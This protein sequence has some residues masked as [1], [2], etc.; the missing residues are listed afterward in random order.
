VGLGPSLAVLGG[1]AAPQQAEAA[2]TTVVNCDDPRQQEQPVVPLLQSYL[3]QVPKRIVDTREALGGHSGPV[4][5]GCTLRLDLSNSIVPDAATSVAL[6]LTA[7]SG[8]RGFMTVFPCSSGRPTP[9]NVNIRTDAPTPNLVVAVPDD[10]RTVCIYSHVDSDMVIDV[11][12]WWGDG[13]DRFTPIDPVR[14]YD[15]RELLPPVKLPAGGIRNLQIGGVYVPDDATSVVINLTAT[16]SDAP[17]WMVAYPCGKAPPKASNLN[18]AKGDI[19]AVAA[20]VKLG[21]SNFG[22]GQICFQTLS[23]THFIVDVVGYYSAA[24][25]F[26]P[27][28]ELHPVQ[29]RL[30][31]TRDGTGPWDAP[32]TA[33][34]IREIDPTVG[35]AGA[36]DT[37]A[38]VLNAIGL[39]AEARGFLTFFPCSAKTPTV[40]TLN[41]FPNRE[42]SNL[43]VVKLSGNG[44]ICVRS[45][46][47]GDVV[48][49][50]VGV[51][52]LP[53]GSPVARLDVTGVDVWPE[54][55]PQGRDYALDCST[56]S[57]TVAFDVVG[58]RG[59][60]VTVGSRTVVP[61][62]PVRLALVADEIVQVTATKAG[63]PTET[64]HFRCL[65]VDFPDLTVEQPGSPEPGWYLTGLGGFNGIGAFTVI[66]DERGVPVWYQRADR[67]PINAQRLRDGTIMYDTSDANGYGVGADEVATIISLDGTILD[68]VTTD[69]PTLFPLDH[70]EH[71]ERPNLGRPSDWTLLSYPLLSGQD[72]TISNPWVASQEFVNEEHAIGG[73]IREVTGGGVLE[74]E[75][76]MLDHFDVAESQYPFRFFNHRPA[77][78][79]GEV[80]LFHINS[81]D[82]LDDGDYVVSARH[83][84]AV[85][86][87]DRA[88]DEVD[89]ILSSGPK[90]GVV[91]PNKNGAPR[92]EIIGDPLG[93]PRRSHDARFDEATNVLT[94][95]DNRTNTGEPARAVA[96]QIDLDAGVDGTA[97]LLWQ[98]DEPFGRS[99]G[100]LGS[101]RVGD[102]GS[103]LIT[104]GALQPMFNEF[105]ANG[106]LMLSITQNPSTNAYRIVKYD[107]TTFDVSTLRASAGSD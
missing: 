29:Q 42:V 48:L 72:I 51:M 32:F 28:A 10:Q 36:V 18:Y 95:F 25:T 67:F 55:T 53:A 6:S 98:I 41:T 89:W 80:D 37:T 43:L 65:P 74:W 92:L 3:S 14:A 23:Q 86:R 17:G 46:T 78:E 2:T 100:G 68:E 27:S 102:D 101:L 19:R 105:D 33:G 15:T 103:R 38:V 99:S 64:Y 12:G 91:V 16:E 35:L 93:G 76:D 70:H 88:T 7:V 26:G 20:I 22:E 54:F 94:L 40:S 84:D 11:Q 1:V 107:R 63:L 69:N 85:F 57:T 87:I 61:D 97:T 90:D 5:A 96:Y 8:A 21:D 77:P 30:V 66:M 71:L 56:G 31:D 81:L 49:D 59:R 4:P 9:S 79:T 13:P 73:W 75:W 50:L 34:E 60:T 82:R 52:R 39:N 24:P 58:H 83:L 62:T 47:G 104:W 44:K 45:H 106:E